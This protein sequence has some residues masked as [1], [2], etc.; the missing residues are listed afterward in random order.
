MIGR[1]VLTFMSVFML[2]YGLHQLVP[3]MKINLL[4]F[5]I[6]RDFRK[7][8]MFSDKLNTIMIK[9]YY[10]LFTMYSATDDRV[11]ALDVDKII[12]SLSGEIFV[13]T[14]GSVL[15]FAPNITNTF[16]T[17][18]KDVALGQI[19]KT[20]SALRDTLD[21]EGYFDH[22]IKSRNDGLTSMYRYGDLVAGFSMEFSDGNVATSKIENGL[23]HRMSA[24]IVL[25]D[26]M[27]NIQTAN[28]KLDDNILLKFLSEIGVDISGINVEDEKQSNHPE[29]TAIST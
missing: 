1:Y 12:R 15:M 9:D 3:L 25:N 7:A 6:M 23:L 4:K 17:T 26:F 21:Y 5:L 29:E 2:L 11:S 10:A 24:Y 22:I 20:Y 28:I 18:I 16:I 19:N 27:N 13:R 8:L 14:V